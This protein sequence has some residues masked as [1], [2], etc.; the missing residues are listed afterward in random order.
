MARRLQIDR[1]RDADVGGS[2]APPEERSMRSYQIQ[3]LSVSTLPSPSA[4]SIQV[5]R[6]CEA[7]TGTGA[8]ARLHAFAPKAQ[9]RAAPAEL[10]A[11]Y[12]G[13]GGFDL[14]LY[15]KGRLGNWL[16]ALSAARARNSV[17]YG[18]NVVASARA[19]RLGR[20]VAIEV[21]HPF[22][23]TRVEHALLARLS[24]TSTCLGLVAISHALKDR[25]V[26]DYPAFD[27]RVLVAPDAANVI[28]APASGANPRPSGFHVGYVGSLYAGKGFMRIVAL[29]RAMPWATFHV[30]GEIDQLRKRGIDVADL[31]AN[32]TLHG[33]Q[34]PNAMA[35][36]LTSFDIVLAPYR[37]EV[38]PHSALDVAP[39]MSPLKLFEYMA[40]RKPIVASDLP[41]IREV[42]AH[43]ETA[44]LCSPDDDGAWVQ[45]LTRLHDDSEMADRLAANAYAL[46]AR[47]YTWDA[48]AAAIRA[49]LD[50]RLAESGQLA[51]G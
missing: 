46:W 26:R 39:W 12:G 9:R 18:R 37:R 38:K 31:P 40:A 7:F 6:M 13:G 43:G 23:E 36:I 19:A 47:H 51:G 15:R 34:P 14:A 35:R 48:R 32:L 50:Q 45:A 8:P 16:M 29:A 25:L 21:H 42:V 2:G 49:W 5:V 33:H 28:Y 3:Y 17:I 27:G 22:A 41:A 1:C 20:P 24:R 44:W 30:V 11:Y 10:A 4:N